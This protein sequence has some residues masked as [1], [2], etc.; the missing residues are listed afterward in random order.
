M[1]EYASLEEVYG[2]PFGKRAP[3]TQTA[4]ATVRPIMKKSEEAVAKHKTLLDSL[5][6]SL[7][8][9]AEEPNYKASSPFFREPSRPLTKVEAFSDFS[10]A[11]PDFELK[12]LQDQ[13]RRILHMVEQNKTGYETPATNDMLLYIFT[14]VFFLFT[15]DQFVELGRHMR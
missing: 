15:F 14:G 6:A 8:I 11:P 1:P 12:Q 13:V 7:P 2:V 5:T 9:T 4:E 10:Y 3:V